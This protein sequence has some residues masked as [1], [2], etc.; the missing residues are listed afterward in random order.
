MGRGRSSEAASSSDGIELATIRT[1]EDNSAGLGEALHQTRG[2]SLVGGSIHVPHA[3]TD[4]L[5][6]LSGQREARI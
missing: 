3:A 4:G 5:E 1:E 6:L 2:E